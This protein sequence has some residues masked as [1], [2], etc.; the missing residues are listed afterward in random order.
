MLRQGS[1]LIEKRARHREFVS[2][3]LILFLTVADALV[4]WSSQPTNR[5]HHSTW[6]QLS[7][8]TTDAS[9]SGILSKDDDIDDM[10]EYWRL[11]D[12][13]V[14]LYA[15]VERSSGGGQDD[16]NLLHQQRRSEVTRLIEDMTFSQ[17]P[18]HDSCGSKPP[19]LEELDL[20]LIH[21]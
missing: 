16:R 21:I 14:E 18:S 15:S 6:L 8:G 7:L 13:S 11:L 2:M 19:S 20:S 17:Y 9:S 5:H 12:A 10:D 4:F 1:S 3:L